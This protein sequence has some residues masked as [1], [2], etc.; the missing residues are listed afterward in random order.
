MCQRNTIMNLLIDRFGALGNI[1]ENKTAT[2]L[3]F[4][5][6]KELRAIRYGVI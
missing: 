5:Q 1:G 3:G 4:D 2:M 6:L